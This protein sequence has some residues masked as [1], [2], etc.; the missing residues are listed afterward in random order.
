MNIIHFRGVESKMKNIAVIPNINKDKW[1]ETTQELCSCFDSNVNIYMEKKFEEYKFSARFVENPFECVECVI[2]LGG[3]GTILRVA[4]KCAELSVPILGINLGRIG[5]MTEIETDSIEKAM[6][7]L[8][9]GAFTVEE[10]MMLKVEIENNGRVS[11]YHALNDAVVSK[12]DD[13][14][15]V[16][17]HLYYGNELIHKYIADGLIISTPTGSTGY[18]LSSGGPVVNPLMDLV[19]ATPICA[20]MI[21]TRPIVMP[22][23]EKLEIVFDDNNRNSAIVTVDGNVCAGIS[24]GDKVTITKSNYTTKIIKIGNQSFYNV[25]IRKLS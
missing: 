17:M 3:D 2:V 8:I 1:Y 16:R 19:L 14:K 4:E 10:R 18:N 9:K 24:N 21:T 5:F 22:T 15:L 13:T 25:F 6:D 7:A 11:T 20:H 23:N 12:T